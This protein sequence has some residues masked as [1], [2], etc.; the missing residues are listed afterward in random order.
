M[1]AAFRSRS[2]AVQDHPII[3]CA[4]MNATRGQETSGLFQMAN[5]SSKQAKQAHISI[6]QAFGFC[7]REGGI[8]RDPYRVMKDE[9]LSV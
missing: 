6:R 5:P 7:I 8:V 3:R 9:N 2:S 4:L 1:G